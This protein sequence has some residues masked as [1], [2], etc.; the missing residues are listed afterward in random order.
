MIR[1]PQAQRP[2]PGGVRRR[3]FVAGAA[4]L[5]LAGCGG[6]E[7]AA[8]IPGVG[9]GGTGIVAGVVT[10]LGSIFVDGRRYDDSRAVLERQPDLLRTETVALSDLQLGQYAYLHMDALGTPMRVRLESQLVGPAA[11]VA[12]RRFTV[13]GQAV[14]VNSD[15]G[16]GPVTVFAGLSGLDELA[17][18][19]AVQVYGLLQP[20]PADPARDLI[21][22][23][24]IERIQHAALPARITGHLR[25][26]GSGW[27]LAGVPLDTGR[28][29]ELPQ[30]GPLAAG[31]AVT[32]V[33]PWPATPGSMPARWSPTA[34]RRLGLPRF[35]ADRMR[36]SGATQ[37]LAGA[38]MVQ[39][40]RIDLAQ[41]GVAAAQAALACASYLTVEGPLDAATGQLTAS[42]LEPMP[43]GGRTM[44][45]H[46]SVTEV[47]A[48]GVFIVRGHRVDATRAQFG[49]ATAGMVTAGR[50]VELAGTAAGEGLTADR[51]VVPSSLPEQAMLDLTGIVQSVD[52]GARTVLLLLAS[53][54]TLAISFGTMMSL[55]RPG[56]TVRAAGVWRGG[57]L[58]VREMSRAGPMR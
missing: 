41:V 18:F 8:L 56:E 28:I 37:L 16:A 52:S 17:Q 39:G 10:G 35:A 45:L 57:M 29:A 2:L 14:A 42:T 40:V 54:E 43:R 36:V 15:P 27:S 32:V 34:L 53:G 51:V 23:T 6:G 58:Q 24:R 11:Q 26:G 49:G 19:D 25:P 38:L 46:G 31:M 20:D 47:L 4:A 1:Y 13:W 50:Y 7:L 5:S 9:T 33:V 48:P 44:E 55:P 21:R 30:Q 12:G 3:S 22:A